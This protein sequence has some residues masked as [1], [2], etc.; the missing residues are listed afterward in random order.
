MHDGYVSVV[1]CLPGF[2]SSKL[3][4]KRVGCF[5]IFFVVVK[6]DFPQILVVNA[7]SNAVTHEFL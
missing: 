5:T 4:F 1:C 6:E 2:C 3:F 7:S